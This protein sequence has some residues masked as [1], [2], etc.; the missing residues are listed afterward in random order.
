MRPLFLC[1]AF[2]ACGPKPAP[3]APPAP[4]TPAVLGP[5]PAASEVVTAAN[6]QVPASHREIL[7]FEVKDSGRKYGA[8]EAIV[9]ANWPYDEATSSYT[10]HPDHLP[11]MN[12]LLGFSAV[13]IHT[14]CAGTCADKD[15]AGLIETKVLDITDKGYVIESDTTSRPGHRLVI[16]KHPD[17]RIYTHF[18]WKDGGHRYFLCE[19]EVDGLLAPAA[20]AF[21]TACSGLVI[22]DWE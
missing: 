7:R 20:E 14:S 4:P 2:A 12:R 10:P 15:W 6:G 16:S 11:P 1:L 19:A 22:Q 8:F 3:P 17:K 5:G 9:P 18:F 13:R 21:K